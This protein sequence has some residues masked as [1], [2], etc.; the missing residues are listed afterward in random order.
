MDLPTFLF[1]ICLDAGEMSIKTSIGFCNKL[2]IKIL[3]APA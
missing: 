2:L 1:S 3:L